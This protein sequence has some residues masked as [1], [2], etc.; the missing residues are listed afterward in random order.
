MRDSELLRLVAARFAEGLTTRMITTEIAVTATDATQGGRLI[1]WIDGMI[2][3]NEHRW[4]FIKSGITFTRCQIKVWRV[5]WLRR[6][7]DI[8]ESENS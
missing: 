5:M 3:E 1:F 2:D 6:L 8:C 7:I 4:I